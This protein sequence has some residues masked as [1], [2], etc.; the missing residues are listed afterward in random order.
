[1]NGNVD[2]FYPGSVSGAA[3]G[4][5]A[6]AEPAL[7]WSRECQLPIDAVKSVTLLFLGLFFSS[8]FEN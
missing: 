7:T 3:E 8:R 2:I 4:S 6:E 1:M 5:A